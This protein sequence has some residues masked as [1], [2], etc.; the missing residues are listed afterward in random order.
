MSY[1]IVIDAGHGGSDN[2]ATYEGRL[3]KDDNLRL[4]LAL[5]KELENMGQ[6]VIMTRTT[7]ETLTL[8]QRSELANQNNADLF[9]ALHR[10]SFPEET[11]WTNGVTNYVHTYASDKS[12]LI[13]EIVLDHLVEVGVQSNKGV[14]RGNYYVLR[15]T[16]MPAM[17]LEVGYIINE[18]DN[19]LFDENLDEYAKAVAEGII[20]AL[21]TVNQNNNIIQGRQSV[22][23][24][25]RMLNYRYGAGLIT[26]GIYGPRTRSALIRAVQTELNNE[27]NANIEVDGIFGPSTK[28]A[29]P[30]LG[31]TDRGNLV[32][33]LQAGLIVKGYNV[34]TMDGVYGNQTRNAV[35]N[36]QKRNGLTT[37]GIA[38][39][40]TFE[41]LLTKL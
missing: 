9:I 36:F 20:D 38:G 1:L 41:K 19:R 3:E 23:Q 7:D 40:N 15:T 2:G 5:Q 16:E 6:N 32:R 25:Q 10:D 24:V 31:Y 4:A 14:R 8:A 30:N 27:Y 22:R 35:I 17:L 26:D 18:E 11:P 37:D 13:A 39:P 28:S 33:L 12:V 21:D 34:G 29:I